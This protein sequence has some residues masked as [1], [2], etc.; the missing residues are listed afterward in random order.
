MY[1]FEDL[2]VYKESQTFSEQVYAITKSWPKDEMF[3]L[4][5]QV[6]RAAVSI[7]LNIAEGT[8]RTKK[9]FAHFLD[10]A[11]GS[12]FECVSILKIAKTIN[13]ITGEQYNF[14]YSQTEVISKMLSGLK[15][16]L[17]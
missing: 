15:T 4:T 3:G 6:R 12:C 2:N 9:D 17:L 7:C 8:S 14:L 1:R 13:Y 16:T 5:N 11:R 10:L